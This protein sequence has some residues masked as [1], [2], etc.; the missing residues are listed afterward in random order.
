M[1]KLTIGLCLFFI[2]TSTCVW[3]MG[4][5]MSQR[6]PREK[7]FQENV[8]DPSS[9]LLL[10]FVVNDVKAIFEILRQCDQSTAKGTVHG[11]SKKF[12]ALQQWSK[13]MIACIDGVIGSRFSSED[14]RIN[15]GLVRARMVAFALLLHEEFVAVQ[16]C[17]R[18]IL[19]EKNST[20]TSF[21]SDGAP[22]MERDCLFGLPF[23]VGDVIF[24]C[25]KEKR[26][27]T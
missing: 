15:A 2:A 6:G 12:L 14:L 16:K 11:V 9:P 26:V 27:M 22:C 4:A 1:T 13:S 24:Q 5:D 25:Q 23:V 20:D 21:P 8:I 17:W 3:A 7:Y 18:Q 19:G 10:C